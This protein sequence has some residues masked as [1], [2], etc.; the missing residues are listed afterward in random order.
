[1]TEFGGDLMRVVMPA[2]PTD[3][4][5]GAGLGPAVADSE[6]GMARR[7][8]HLKRRVVAFGLVSVIDAVLREPSPVKSRSS[9]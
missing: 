4:I 2:A 5:A 3:Q 7:D 8:R 9:L 1:M 6:H